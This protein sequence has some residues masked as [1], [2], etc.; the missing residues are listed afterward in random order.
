MIKLYDGGVYLVNGQELCTCEQEVHA[1][2]GKA[3]SKEE[4]ARGTIAYGIMKSHNQSEKS[5][6]C[7]LVSKHILPP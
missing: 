1:K 4:A 5:D 2:T 7:F 3:V 6:A